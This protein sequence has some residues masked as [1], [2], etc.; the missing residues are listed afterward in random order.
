[1]PCRSLGRVSEA[2]ARDSLAPRGCGGAS[3]PD[4][5]V[6]VGPLVIVSQEVPGDQRCCLLSAS[7]IEVPTE[8]AGL[9][10]R[11]SPIKIHEAK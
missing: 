3:P 7:P 6:S 9:L 8:R 2:L 1:M 10:L 5:R 11:T 4:A